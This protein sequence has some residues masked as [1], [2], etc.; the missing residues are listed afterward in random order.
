MFSLKKR[1]RSDCPEIRL[2]CHC[3][4]GS[5][6]SQIKR[7]DKSGAR[8]ALILGEDEA[9]AGTVG[10]KY[11]REDRPQETVAQS[12]LGRLFNS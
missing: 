5:F 1:L 9:A 10:V 4:G 3:G 12:D 6:K 2:E 7:A 8:I 11:L